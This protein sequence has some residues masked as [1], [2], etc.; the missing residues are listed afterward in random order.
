MAQ[1]PAHDPAQDIAP[2]LVGRHD[3]VSNNKGCG[4]GVVGSHAKRDV[5]L[6]ISSVASPTQLLGRADHIAQQVRVIRVAAH[7]LQ[8][9]SHPL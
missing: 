5:L 6:G 2:T 1:G 9:S 7:A 8:H 4:P 3:T